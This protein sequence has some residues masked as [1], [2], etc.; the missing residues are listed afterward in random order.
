[1]SVSS[2]VPMVEDYNTLNIGY[3]NHR[4]GLDF[5]HG[6]CSPRVLK[7]IDFCPL[8]IVEINSQMQMKQYNFTEVTTSSIA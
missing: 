6:L 3:T 5:R 2:S 7:Q 8:L 1:M 4:F